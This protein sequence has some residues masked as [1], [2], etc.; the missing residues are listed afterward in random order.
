MAC[1]GCQRLVL[2]GTI[3]IVSFPCAWAGTHAAIAAASSKPA[4]RRKATPT[5][6]PP[7]TA[8]PS[9]PVPVTLQKLVVTGTAT[10]IKQLDAGYNIDTANREQI[11]ALN[12]LNVG[13]LLAMVSPGTWSEP[14]GGESS[15]ATEVAGFPNT[16]GA[17]FST[18]MVNGTPLYGA[19]Q[20][21]YMDTST[22]MR[23]D[24]TISR[25]EVVQGG[26]GAIFGPG[27][28]GATANFIL[29]AGTPAPAGNV[30]LTYGS[31]NRQRLD[32]FYGFPVARDWYASV[33]G[34]YR[35]SDGIRN[36]QYK[37]DQGGQYT[38]TLEHVTG[39]SKL[40][41]WARLLDDDN[42]F[43]KQIPIIQDPD[44]SFSAYPGFDP[45]TGI[46]NSFAIQHSQVPN[47]H[48]GLQDVN[49]AN[50]RGANMRFF[51]G[52]YNTTLGSWTLYDHAL[53]SDGYL[54]TAAL[55]PGSNPEPLSYYLYG[56][57]IPQPAG[58]CTPDNK[59]VNKYT[60]NYPA[61]RAVLATLPNGQIVPLNQSII[62]QG[63][64]FDY[65]HLKS[66]TNDFRASYEI[67]PD[68]TLTTG[69]YVAHYT[70]D[71][72]NSS[73][74]QMLMLNQPHTR[75]IGLT[76]IDD[77]TTYTQANSQGYVNFNHSRVFLSDGKA[78]NVALY[79]SDKWAIGPWTLVAGARVENENAHTH[80]CN[81]TPVDLDGN[82]LTL[83]DNKT[84]ICNDSWDSEHYNETHPS[85][86]AS[87]NYQFNSH[88]SVYLNGMTG[89]HFD[90]FSH[91]IQNAH[92]EYPPMLEIKD[93]EA[94]FRYQTESWLVNLNV[95]HRLFTGIQYQETDK[96]GI[97]IPGAISTYGSK[98]HGLNLILK[99]SP[100][101]N[102]SLTLIGNYL[103]GHYTD[104]N[105]CVPG[106]DIN[107]VPECISFN[108][109]P[110]AR[111]PQ[112]HYMFTP[113]YTLPT[114]WGNLTMWVTYNHVGQRYQDQTGMQPLGVYDT[115]AAGIVANVGPHWQFRL[116]GTN[117]T[118]EFGITEGNTH[119]LGVNAGVGGV[120]MARPLFGRE[121]FL[122]VKYYF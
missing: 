107:G 111:Q 65:K 37:A 61:D 21:S 13:E 24:D 44:G 8:R 110:L 52:S 16:H 100:V 19:A 63:M 43:L 17:P 42:L 29:R 20:L 28:I 26:T 117:L 96:N 106:F 6:P 76:Y 56:C 84:P 72:N 119:V 12:P 10:G 48:G 4:T 53:F 2:A 38:A 114:S 108:G 93:I 79:L 14:T 71:D 36:P 1:V 60:L 116:Q 95:Y 27:Q 39:N 15:G 49:L 90:D 88:M 92:G 18:V 104:N 91:G 11:Q 86:A 75:P 83:Y 87:V 40:L 103:D 54:P 102:L 101:Q 62:V 109:N 55:F 59:P 32:G 77:G 69:L 9:Q 35:V 68:N 70:S 7:A 46:Y 85:F 97:P 82:P 122:Q 78:T 33:G 50:G 25:V 89:G 66:L 121:V 64:T 45:L 57:N 22:L 23:L 120:I 113:S 58:Y 67:F 5:T 115:L 73:G 118:N 31:E 105:A 99:W 41:L 34:F 81:T 94:G 80:T 74:N 30:G 3:L 112:V 98:S 47:P 51:G